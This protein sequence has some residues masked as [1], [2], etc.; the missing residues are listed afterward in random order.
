MYVFH[1]GAGGVSGTAGA[2]AWSAVG[3]HTVDSID[4]FGYSVASA[5]DVN[6]DGYGDIV[7]G[8]PDVNDYAGKVYVFHGGVGG[9]TGT[10][11]S[12]A[13][14]AEGDGQFSHFGRP[15][16]SA[17][18]VNG[19]GYGDIIV[20]APF[21]NDMAGKVYVFYGGIGGLTGTA[22]SPAWSAQG[23]GP[24][25]DFGTA[26]AGAGDVNGDGCGDIIVGAPGANDDAGKVYVFYG[27]A[28]GVAGMVGSA[29]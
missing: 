21:A 29:A 3:E 27:G 8:T 22:G 7:V 23:E 12:P 26:A 6:G 19:D 16:A 4:H 9:L 13:W 18:D 15:V 1:G 20:G 10:A 5:G 2:P 25:N 11:G 14:S 28:G 24:N 17:G